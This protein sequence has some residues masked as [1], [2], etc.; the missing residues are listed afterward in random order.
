MKILLIEDDQA[1]NSSLKASLEHEGYAVTPFL[2][3]AKALKH[4]LLN[5]MDYDMV[6]V[7]WMLP[8]KS[9]VEI[10]KEAR[11]RKVQIPMLMLTGKDATTD[12][13][14][15]L[16]S[17][18]DDY[19]TKPFS[20]DELLARVRA[21][22]RRPKQALKNELA[23]GNIILNIS[24]RKVYC[25]NKEVQLTLKEFNILEYFIRHPNQVLTRDEVLDHVW[26]YNFSS[27]SN[28]MDVHINNLRKKLKKAGD[29][30]SIETVRGVG[31]RLKVIENKND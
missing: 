15:A 27:F 14:N 30:A 21:L 17:G 2:D 10:C 5:S 25:S 16:D 31:Y 20:L 26:D 13:V 24:T 22:M 7:D 28:I 4:L 6:I 23:C 19:L 3:G 12:K 8:G 1:L 29:S 9:G 18:A 11:E